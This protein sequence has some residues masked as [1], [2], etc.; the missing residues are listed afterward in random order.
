MPLLAI[1]LYFSACGL[2]HMKKHLFLLCLLASCSAIGQNTI[3]IPNIVNYTKL[4]YQSGSQNWNITQDKNGIMYF[5][6]NEGLLSF[7][8]TYW[9]TYPL[10]NKTIVRSVAISSDNKIYVG[11]QKEIGYFLPGKNGDLAYTSLN[12]LLNE[13]DNDFADVWNICF[14][15]GHV[16]FRANKKILDYHNNKIVAYNSFNWGFL[17]AVNGEMIAYEIDKGL[18]KFK[19]GQWLPAIKSGELPK[20]NIYLR[21]ALP[22]GKDSILLVSL[23]HGLFVLHHDTLTAFTSPDIK[24]IA[25]Q[26]ISAACLLFADRIAFFTNLAGCI[27]ISKEGKFIQH[28]TKQEGIQNNNARTGFLDKDKNLWLGLD[29]GIDLVTYS[30]AIKN[31]FPDKEDRNTGYTSLIFNNQ[32]YL[33]VSTAV[34]KINL[35][36]SADLSYTNG[37]FSKVK[38]SEGQ[39]WNLAAINGKLLLGHNKGGYLIE[40][41]NATPIDVKTGF[42]GFYPLPGHPSS[43]MLAGT[44][45]GINF[46]DN[47]TNSTISS[48]GT[49]QFESARFI[50]TGNNIIWAAHPYKGIY[51]IEFDKNNLPV[52]TN[53]K[54]RKGILSSN[55]NKIFKIGDK[56]ILISD[57]GIFEYAEKEKDFVR[58]DWFE[59]LV[60]NLPVSYIKEDQRGNIWFCRDR[61]VGVID[62]SGKEPRTIF[63]PEIDNR[64]ISNG[65]ENINIIDS[66]NVLI[67]AE[68]G[69]FHINYTL[70]KKNKL[71]LQ[72]LVRKVQSPLGKNELIYGGYGSISSSPSIS[73]KYNALH[74]ECSS[75]LYGQEQNTDYSYYLEGFDKDWTAWSQKREKDYTNLPPGSYVFKVKCRNNLDSESPVAEFS[76]SILPPWY[77]TWWAYTLYIIIF[78]GLL[79]MFYK[80]QSRKYKRLQQLKL[81]EQ[82]RKYDEEQKQLQLQ[83]QLEIQE[84]E[85]QIVELKNAKLQSEVEH[86]NSELASSAMNLVRKKEMLS[87][88]KEDLVHYKGTPEDK[89]AKEF[90]KIIRVIDKELDHNEEWEQFAV[91]F[92]SVHTNY[93]KKLKDRFP[94]LSVS[95]LKLA[96]YLR[97]NLTSKE[98]AQ[99]MNIS[100]RGV[101][102]SRY[103]LR[104]KLGI[105]NEVNLFDFLT[106]VTA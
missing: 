86:K 104:K 6:N 14:L 99:L 29:N 56:I 38:N 26:N 45:S 23:L 1:T 94:A 68:K 17:G 91:H 96:A 63:I 18:L 64:I 69:F 44:Y 2:P 24:N 66:N 11:G 83:H 84:S 79:Y 16:F 74:F 50:A 71:P 3:G 70:Y 87:K 13:K 36:K 78:F 10:P 82:Q 93:L 80:R 9:R 40:N 35:D 98:I 39:V 95:D 5:A 25:T 105:D 19:N 31:I 15:D 28:F 43:M 37:S 58:A 54:D 106:K 97:L 33:G 21:T 100:I 73:Y 51:S 20:D 92:D 49:A 67:A 59:R 65:F 48:A 75:T 30:N 27:I 72:V 34:Y 103:R 102:T 60:G 41:D 77:Q 7:D 12:K 85:K 42:W 76:F 57:N 88:L 101:E 62:R 32:L 22:F 46:Y 55:H 52:V 89:S 81:Q 47:K 61:K 8:G 90:Q 53:Y 4:A